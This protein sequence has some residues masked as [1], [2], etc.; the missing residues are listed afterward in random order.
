MALRFFQGQGDILLQ[1]TCYTLICSIFSDNL[2]KYIGYIEIAVGLGL[3]LGPGIGSAVN[4]NVGYAGTMYFFGGLNLL[5]MLIVCCMLPSE[6][7]KTVSAEECAA[8]EA[9]MEDLAQFEYKET[10]GKKKL[11]IT[12]WTVWCN[13]SSFCALLVILVGCFNVTFFTGFVG[14]NLAA[15]VEGFNLSESAIGVLYTV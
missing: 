9:E 1:I 2:L 12:A 13:K 4:L 6:L 14:V 10:P 7:N 3:G 8:F 11:K 5:G 15:D